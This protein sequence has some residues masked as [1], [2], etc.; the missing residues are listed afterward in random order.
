MNDISR[1]RGNKFR[2]FGLKYE[3]IF[4]E[5]EVD[6]PVAELRMTVHGSSSIDALNALK[7]VRKLRP[8][9]SYSMVSVKRGNYREYVIQELTYSGRFVGRGGTSIDDYISLIEMSRKMYRNTIE[10]IE[11]SSI[12]VKKVEGRTLIEGNAFDFILEREIP[13]ISTFIEHL[14]SSTKPFRLWGLKNRI[15]EDYYQVVC[16]DLHTG[17]LLNLE[18]SPNLIRVYLPK[19]ACGNTVLRLFTNLQHYY[20]SAIKI[21]DEKIQINL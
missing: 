15:F 13:N 5:K 7:K 3:D 6:I 17:D 11:R 19:N 10:N 8:S 9:I 14:L 21:N 2:G 18:V 12:G 16:V 20:D 4:T 1:I